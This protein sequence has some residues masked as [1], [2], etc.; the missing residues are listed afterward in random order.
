MA[1]D[2]VL[3]VALLIN[4]NFILENNKKVDKYNNRQKTRYNR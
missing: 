2:R 1:E 4:S 3:Q